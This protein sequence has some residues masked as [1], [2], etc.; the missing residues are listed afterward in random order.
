MV[1]MTGFPSFLKLNGIPLF[2]YLFDILISYP[3]DIHPAVPLLNPEEV[4]LLIIM[5][6]LRTVC[7]SGEVNLHS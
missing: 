7:Y 4:L 6:K 1:E 2:K 3:L 5:K